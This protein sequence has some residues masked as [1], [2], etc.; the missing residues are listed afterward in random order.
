M[1]K[2]AICLY[3]NLENIISLFIKIILNF[4]TFYCKK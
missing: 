4:F 1:K 2:R 3:L